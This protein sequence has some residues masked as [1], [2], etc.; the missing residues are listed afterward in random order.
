MDGSKILEEQCVF[1]SSLDSLLTSSF[2]ATERDNDQRPGYTAGIAGVAATRATTT[3][4]LAEKEL[5]Q[6]VYME[7]KR[8]N[9][10]NF[11]SCCNLRF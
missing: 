2:L 1:V 11:E 6:E 4:T 8:Q 9:S 7:R 3:T 5:E 10:V